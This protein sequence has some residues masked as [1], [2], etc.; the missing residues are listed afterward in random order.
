M[1]FKF[2]AAATA[3]ALFAS[4]AVWADSNIIFRF[5]DPESEAMRAALDE[6]EV[7]NPDIS[8][9]LQSFAWSEARQQFLREAAVGE[10]PD[11]VH[12]AFVW[13]RD[14]GTAGALYPLNEFWEEAPL[15][16]GYDDFI[17]SNLAIGADGG[18]YGV[19]WT[20]DTWA[21][22]YRTDI[23]EDAGITAPAKNWDELRDISRT[24]HE[25]TGKIGFGFPAGSG[26]QSTIWFLANYYWWS[27]G[28][29]LVKADGDGFDVG[30]TEAQIAEAMEYFDSYMKEGH[31]PQ[32][33]LGVTDWYDPAI[34]EGMTNGDQGVAIVPPQQA[35]EIIA[36]YE[37]RHPG[38]EAPFISAMVPAGSEASS[39]HLGG[40][41][42]GINSNSDEPEA[43][44]K[45]IEFLTRPEIIAKYYGNQFPA[46]QTPLAQ[47]DFGATMSGFAEQLAVARTWGAY[48]DGPAQIG[49]MWNETGRMF[50]SAFIGERSYDEAAEELLNTVKDML[51]K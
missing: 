3:I 9:E 14:L 40:R 12:I 41:M 50:G 51:D 38:E 34:I 42:L 13:P 26:V 16:A 39:T 25:E 35:R 43:A 36:A 44:W 23:M 30:I 22:L 49:S 29:A 8:V 48:S 10:G 5:N 46:Q 32:S 31:N 4:G 2:T 45:L 20:T 7:E 11:V 1:T 47:I 24:I 33:M 37:K 28:S 17:A 15:Q 6:F 18:I 21:M 19:P 27:N